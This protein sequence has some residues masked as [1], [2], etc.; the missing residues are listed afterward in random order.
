MP[1]TQD[2]DFIAINPVVNYVWPDGEELPMSFA[3]G[4]TAMRKFGKVFSGCNKPISHPLRS[5]RIEEFD[6]RVNALDIQPRR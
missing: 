1:H 6:V 2:G 5:R 4:L 3:R